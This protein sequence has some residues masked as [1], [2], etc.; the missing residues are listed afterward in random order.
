MTRKHKY[1]CDGEKEDNDEEV[2]L[3]PKLNEF[4]N[5]IICS[6]PTATSHLTLYIS[7]S[8]STQT[9]GVWFDGKVNTEAW[10]DGMKPISSENER[11]G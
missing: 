11:A 7:S 9:S 4:L 2:C 8:P 6:L 3:S 10:M 5:S 1:S